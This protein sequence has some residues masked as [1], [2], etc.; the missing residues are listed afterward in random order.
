M[1]QE[2]FA[3]RPKWFHG[4]Q[5]RPPAS[6]PDGLCCSS[7]ATESPTFNPSMERKEHRFR[8]GCRDPAIELRQCPVLLLCDFENA[9]AVGGRII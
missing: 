4:G 7:R 6:H 5:T 1:F 3:G 8:R 2:H 9:A